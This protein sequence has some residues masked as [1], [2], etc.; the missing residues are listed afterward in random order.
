LCETK[1]G[2]KSLLSNLEMTSERRI[3]KELGIFTEKGIDVET[4][5]ILHWQLAMNGPAETPYFGGT[6]VLDITFPKDYP[7]SA[8]DVFFLTKIYHPNID[9]KGKICLDLLKDKWSPTLTVYKI[10]EA[11]IS[12]LKTPNPSDPLFVEA[13]KLYTENKNEYFNKAFEVTKKYA[14]HEN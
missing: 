4:D 13:A 6:F 12:L 3:V 10:W 9:H 2:L 11:V 14:M 8:P 1:K 7:F 5:R